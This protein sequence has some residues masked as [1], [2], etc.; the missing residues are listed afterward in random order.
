MKSLGALEVCFDA[1]GDDPGVGTAK[2]FDMR[3]MQGPATG[4]NY[5]GAMEV[6]N[7]PGPFAA[8]V[9]Q[10]HTIDSLLDETKYSIGLTAIDD[11]GN[12][13]AIS[14][15][16]EMS[17][18]GVPP[19]SITTL[20]V[21]N[22]GKTTADLSW[23]SPSDVGSGVMGYDVRY[24]TDM[25][26]ASNFTSAM[27]LD[28]EPG[29]LAPNTLQ[30]MP[31]IDLPS[32]STLYLAMTSKDM[33]N[34]VSG[35]SNV[36]QIV[37]LDGKA[38]GKTTDLNGIS[39]GSSLVNQAPL[40]ASDVSG[41]RTAEGMVKENVVDGNPASKWMSPAAGSPTAPTHITI[42]LGASVN[43]AQVSLQ[44]DNK[45]AKRFPRGFNI[46]VSD[47]SFL[48]VRDHSL[49]SRYR[50]VPSEWFTFDVT[51][52][53]G[54]VRQDRDYGDEPVWRGLLRC[55]GTGQSIPSP[56]LERRFRSYLDG[57]ANDF[58]GTTGSADSYDLRYSS[59][60]ILTDGDFGL[61]TPVDPG[62][63]SD[64]AT[65]RLFRDSV[66]FRLRTR[67]RLYPGP[68]STDDNNNVSV[69]STSTKVATP[70]TPPDQPVGLS[71]TGATGS[72]LTLGWTASADDAG[73][74]GSGSV[75]H[76]DVRCATTPINNLVDFL[77]APSYPGPAPMSPGAPESYTV[78]PLLNQTMYY[79]AGA[80]GRRRRQRLDAVRHSQR[81]HARRDRS[82]AA[83]EPLRRVQ[84]QRP[85][86]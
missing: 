33:E 56:G 43:V 28:G 81:K 36:V 1:P 73:D 19:T 24:S 6:T 21:S 15:I 22:V 27:E 83:L 45:N 46:Q 38:P 44:A 39:G 75:D 31:A 68:E 57:P 40:V 48:R 74:N 78:S 47:R 30:M 63:A 71:I 69:L 41:E 61:A 14:N 12:I 20:A 84:R 32:N 4:F 86:G 5:A 52:T 3:Y 51:P 67:E 7:E 66:A 64:T 60:D 26:D 50:G 79:C 11:A 42:N 85:A 77:A 13:S 80:G 72:S 25:I 23:M 54:A 55:A 34:N 29:V 9:K 17:T 37:T 18:K 16:L 59:T 70:G 2:Y 35:I 8:G 76:Y 49:G 53:I 10:C 65:L 82:S 58:D 62:D